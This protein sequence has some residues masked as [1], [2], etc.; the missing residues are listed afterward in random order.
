MEEE[1]NL[2]PKDEGQDNHEEVTNPRMVKSYRAMIPF[3]QRLAKAKLEAKF[4]K[5]L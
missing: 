5:I 1:V 4:E 2:V 3:I